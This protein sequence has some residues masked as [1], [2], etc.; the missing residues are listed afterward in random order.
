MFDRRARALAAPVLDGAASHLE[1]IGLGANSL[2]A[3]GWV[4]GVGAFA[5]ASARAWTWALVAWLA[6]RLF[7]GLDGALARRRGA[8]DFGGYLDVLAD[9][10]VYAGLVV[11]F[12]VALPGTRIAGPALLFSYVMS[13]SAM[14]AAS[15]MLDRRQVSRSD[16][17]TVRFLGGIAEGLETMVAYVVIMLA[18]R[19]AAGVE[20]VFTVLVLV[21]AMQRITWTRRALALERSELARSRSS[22][23]R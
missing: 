21:T 18:P 6:N 15:P 12:A 22:V 23:A 3:I 4:A 19:I 1:R 5:A 16:E 8:T 10:S 20:W 13:M 9:F 11:A 2:T 14:L 17:R 7:D